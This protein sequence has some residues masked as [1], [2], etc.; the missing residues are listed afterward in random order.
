MKRKKIIFLVVISVLSMVSLKDFNH[1][2]FAPLCA[3]EI[4]LQQIEKEASFSERVDDVL[5]KIKI[6]VVTTPVYFLPKFGSGVPFNKR[7]QEIGFKALLPSSTSKASFLT[8]KFANSSKIPN[9]NFKENDLQIFRTSQFATGDMDFDAIKFNFKDRPYDLTVKA[10][11]KKGLEAK[12]AVIIYN[13][14][15]SKF[16]VSFG[17]NVKVDKNGKVSQGAEVTF[18][19][20]FDV[21]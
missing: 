9:V 10:N 21:N 3:S 11:P 14:E 4:P 20:S 15:D 6:H 5:D 8:G 17:P 12:T 13:N 2:F 7:F 19:G 18:S 1:Y 16:K